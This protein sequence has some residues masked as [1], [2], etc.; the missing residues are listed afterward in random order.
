MPV[1]RVG[2]LVL[3]AVVGVLGCVPHPQVTE[4]LERDAREK[5]AGADQGTTRKRAE[6]INP[7]VARHDANARKLPEPDLHMKYFPRSYP[8][9][10]ST[11]RSAEKAFY[12]SVLS[13]GRFE[14]LLVPFQVQD[15]AFA[16]DLRSLMTAQLAMAIG[17]AGKI[18]IP[19]PYLVARALG[20]GERGFDLEDVFRLANA[21]G[22]KRIVAGYV[23]H[24][25]T[26]RH[27]MRV[28]LHVYERNAGESFTSAEFAP[29][30]GYHPQKLVASDRLKSQ[31]FDQLAFSNEST[32]V[33]VFEANLPRMLQFLGWD[34]AQ[35]GTARPVSPSVAGALPKS[36]LAVVD[37]A[38]DAA[39]DAYFLQLMAAL[40]PA[41][42][43]R[44]R[45]RFIEKSM[46]AVLRMS[47]ES[48][49]YRVLKARALMYIGL[50]PAA[51]HVLGTPVT[52]EAK[53]LFALLNGNLPEVRSNRAAV[54]AG[55][56]ALLALVEESAIAA[57]YRSNLKALEKELAAL[58]LPGQVWPYLAQ[59]AVTDLDDWSQHD[60]LAL[61]V[62]LDRELPVEGFTAEAL[63]GGARALGDASRVRGAAARSVLEH[64]RKH[65]ERSAAR[66]CCPPL[67][68]RFTRGDFLD[69]VEGIGTDNLSRQ[70]RFLVEVQGSP[71][72]ARRFVADLETTFR[73]HPDLMVPRALA[74]VRLAHNASGAERESL[75]RSSYTDA[76]NAWYWEQGQTRTANRA[77]EVLGETG[78]MD[79]GLFYNAYADDYPYRPFYT[80]WQSGGD[81]VRGEAAARAALDNSSFEIEPLA[82]LEWVMGQLYKRW[83]DVDAL[84]KSVDGRFNGNT[85]HTKLLAQSSVR[86]GDLKSAEQY[87]MQGIRL[88]PDAEDS[89]TALGKMHFENG[90]SDKAARVFMSYPGLKSRAGNPVGLSNYAYEAGSLYYWS[91]D[92]ARAMPLYRIAADLNTGSGASMASA[93]RLA[94]LNGDYAAALEGSLA[95]AQRY[96]SPHAYRDYLGLLHA[97]GFS[98]EA[99]EGFAILIRDSNQPQV[100]ETALVGHRLEGKS[101]AELAA[102]AAQEPMRSAG[103]QTPLAPIY[104]LRAAVI[105][106]AP[107]ADLPERIASLERPVL[108]LDNQRQQIV[109]P[110]ADGKTQHVLGPDSPQPAVLPLGVFDQSKKSRVKSDLVYYAEAFAS[111]GRGEFAQA[112][113]ALQ[114]ASSMYD[115]RRESL[116]Y[117]LAPYAYAAARS[118]DVS[119]LEKRLKNFPQIYQRFDYHLARAI[120]SG[121]GGKRDESIQ[122]L[123]LALVRRPFTEL[124]PIYTEYQYAE[125]CEWL[126]E[127]TR[128]RRYRDIAVDWAK[129]NQA[130]NPWFAWP[131]AVEARL[132]TNPEQRGRA[133]AMAHYLDRNSRRLGMVPKA[134]VTKA[135]KE[136]AQRNPFR[137]ALDQKPRQPA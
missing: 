33:D 61:K 60:N 105:D 76:Y 5:Q 123:R 47:P 25:H 58:K 74:E 2:Y 64:V 51:L 12:A 133:I 53:H 37:Q 87:Y 14:V 59:H 28:T 63:V 104:L 117:L 89:Y 126:F 65:T 17:E 4:H 134:E 27:S 9:P 128:D 72:S 90:A 66:A 103:T 101:E 116:G 34:A 81:P 52:P 78:R 84:M 118:G 94:L 107:S 23:G 35:P 102:W 45:E 50:R 69:L 83:Q 41:S 95:R 82:Y 30:P 115:L 48:P 67:A 44:V 3:F 71:E 136:H 40:S 96:N 125:V 42:A 22:A 54:P 80:F 24:S 31:H 39:R 113:A 10:A 1:K 129:K 46:L 26:Q 73:D 86:K 57:R 75:L 6:P 98:R 70:A 43:S 120:V 100:W 122:H 109:R 93:I 18:A 112:R 79:F 92:F 55:I 56:K 124:R 97:L 99:W 13:K 36:P 137:R 91:G 111:I 32:P 119:A 106:R 16:R 7:E 62:L 110:S 132:G 127:T 130:L 29:R 85:V 88:Q 121:V 19:D 15:L 8:R 77:F 135:V 68:P 131:W 20:D 49:D 114:E 21:I 38:A 11:W 108:R